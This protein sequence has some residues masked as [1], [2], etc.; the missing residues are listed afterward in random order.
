MCH[1]EQRRW[2]R[3]GELPKE[4]CFESVNQTP[5][6]ECRKFDSS[7][8]SA[9]DNGLVGRPSRFMDST[10][11]AWANRS[12]FEV[13][14]PG[15]APWRLAKDHVAVYIYSRGQRCLARREVCRPARLITIDKACNKNFPDS[16]KYM[17]FPRQTVHAQLFD[18]GARVRDCQS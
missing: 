18:S 5:A 4:R 16:R 1:A 11:I 2:Q 8:D 9:V 13:G 17:Y 7:E 12:A 3:Q 14:S 15:A 10:L 6:S